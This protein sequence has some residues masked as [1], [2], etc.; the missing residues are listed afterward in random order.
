DL[1]GSAR[2]PAADA[3]AT[4]RARRGETEERATQLERQVAQAERLAHAHR[5]ALPAA[6]GGQ[7]EREHAG[8]QQRE[9]GGVAAED[10]VSLR[11]LLSAEQRRSA[12]LGEQVATLE[13]ERDGLRG[14]LAAEEDARRRLDQAVAALQEELQAG[15]TDGT[16]GDAAR[17]ELQQAAPLESLSLQAQLVAEESKV[18]AEAEEAVELQWRLQSAEE[19]LAACGLARA[20]ALAEASHAQGGGL[21]RRVASLEQEVE[22]ARS[23]EMAALQQRLRAVRAASLEECRSLVRELQVSEQRRTQEATEAATLRGHLDAREAWRSGGPA[24]DAAPCG[25][26]EELAICRRKLAEEE[27]LR[28]AGAAAAAAAARA[29]EEE[30]RELLSQLVSEESACYAESLEVASLRWRLADAAAG[31]G[32]AALAQ[33]GSVQ[34]HGSR[35]AQLDEATQRQCLALQDK[36]ERLRP[37]VEA[38]AERERLC[39]GG[40]RR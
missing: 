5:R 4:E 20:A 16:A 14:R 23:Q 39:G 33:V 34:L 18:H 15:R 37:M 1:G 19:S 28:A 30:C 7:P 8:W 29:C 9:L 32:T 10:C 13:R 6:G 2:H 36:I 24:R 3:L 27:G 38:I 26:Q 11:L 40:E 35:L 22:R 12:R 21:Q 25:Q 17:L 31:Q